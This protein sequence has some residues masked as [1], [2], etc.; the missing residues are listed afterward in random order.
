MTEAFYIFLAG[1]S[2]GVGREIARCLTQQQ[3]KVFEVYKP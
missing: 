2:R 1:A 3:L